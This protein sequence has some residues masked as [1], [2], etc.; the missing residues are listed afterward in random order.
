MET[1]NIEN[2]MVA[3]GDVG[4]GNVGG[5]VCVDGNDPVEKAKVDNSGLRS[6]K[7]VGPKSSRGMRSK[8]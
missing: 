8:P 5:F 3:W 6:M 2:R 1:V 7:M 4:S